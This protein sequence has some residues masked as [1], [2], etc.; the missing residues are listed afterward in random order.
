MTPIAQA[1]EY[2]AVTDRLEALT[3]LP[4]AFFNQNWVPFALGRA[5]RETFF[6]K[7]SLFATTRAR[8]KTKRDLE[9]RRRP[10][11][12]ERIDAQLE[13]AAM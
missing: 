5:K 3:G 13:S 1:L 2:D 9:R 8:G 12:L 6:F 11:R 10:M 4:S 7:K